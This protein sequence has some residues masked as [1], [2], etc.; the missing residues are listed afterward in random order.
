ML[1]TDSH[2]D[3]ARETRFLIAIQ[4]HNAFAARFARKLGHPSYSGGSLPV[5]AL[6]SGGGERHYSRAK[7]AGLSR[8]PPARPG[9]SIQANPSEC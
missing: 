7:I 6:A 1:G 4:A 2:R 8:P 5:D 9:E 3:D